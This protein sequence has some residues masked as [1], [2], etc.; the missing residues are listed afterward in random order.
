MA[1]ILQEETPIE[2]CL[3]IFFKTYDWLPSGDIIFNPYDSNFKR[4]GY[5]KFKPEKWPRGA[6]KVS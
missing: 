1:G 6:Q 5:Y 4:V 3:F 2:C